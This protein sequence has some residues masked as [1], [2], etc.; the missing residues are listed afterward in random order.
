VQIGGITHA[1]GTPPTAVLERPDHVRIHF[2]FNWNRS[3]VSAITPLAVFAPLAS[4]D[5]IALH[6]QVSA[7]TP[8]SRRGEQIRVSGITP[9]SR[10]SPTLFRGRVLRA[11]ALQAEVHLIARQQM[12]AFF[13]PVADGDG[14]EG[15]VQR[16]FQMAYANRLSG[17]AENIRQTRVAALPYPHLPSA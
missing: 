4:A 3:F 7:T 1:A 11:P 14:H 6:M 13:A 5:Q 17:L 15:W 10:R 12:K 9:L 16:V 2:Q 8:L